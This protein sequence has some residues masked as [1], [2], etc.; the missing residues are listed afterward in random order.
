MKSCSQTRL[1]NE[2]RHSSLIKHIHTY[3]CSSVAKKDPLDTL[4]NELS[5]MLMMKRI[6]NFSLLS[7]SLSPVFLF[8]LSISC[9]LPTRLDS[10]A[11]GRRDKKKEVEQRERKAENFPPHHLPLFFIFLS[12]LFL[13]LFLSRLNVFPSNRF[14][15][16]F[17]H[18]LLPPLHLFSSP[19]FSLSSPSFI[20]PQALSSSSVK[21]Q[22]S[23]KKKLFSQLFPFVRPFHLLLP[24]FFIIAS[25]FFLYAL[26]AFLLSRKRWH[27]LD[28]HLS[29]LSFSFSLPLLSFS[30]VSLSLIFFLSF[31]DE[32]D[33]FPSPIPPLP[34]SSISF[35]FF[36]LLQL[37][38]NWRNVIKL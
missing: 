25:S 9:S 35:L 23:K 3:S 22:T 29:L 7:S 27:R 6:S 26:G 12:F 5:G 10:E 17:T 30:L 24:F 4:G 38:L 14:T 16:S 2:S 20:F 13:S 21:L 8:P 33:S 36:F 32:R 34:L 18:L 19:S 28:S 11:G 31:L 37:N 1:N 15:A